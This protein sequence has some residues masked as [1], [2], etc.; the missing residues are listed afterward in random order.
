TTVPQAVVLAN[1]CR[2]ETLPGWSKGEVAVQDLGA[3]VA[4]S[5]WQTFV[6]P[7]LYTSARKQRPLRI[8]DACTAPGGKLFHLLEILAA[9]NI[10][11]EVVALESSAHRAT[12]TRAAAEHL[13]HTVDL[14]VA[15]ATTLDWWSGVPFDHVL[16][17]APCSGTGTLRR[18]PDIKVLL[19]EGQI[20]QHAET[21]LQ[22]L[23]NLWRTVSAGGTLLYCTCSLLEEENDL[24]IDAFLADESAR[25]GS[26]S[27]N[28]ADAVQTN[29]GVT[30]QVLPLNLA[31]GYQRRRGWQ[32]SPIEPT[33][34]GFYY[35][36]LH[37]PGPH[38]TAT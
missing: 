33:T 13:G 1:P 6:Q 12:Q 38:Q 4:G 30:P 20:E 11:A 10:S 31:S 27:K 22:L 14:H 36:L 23:N 18:H 35:A 15:D 25:P 8:L 5:I 7:T 32:L 26:P 19:Q 2:V 17:D 34:D 24:V 37:K 9:N 3:Q 29:T 16:L 28:D 21:Q